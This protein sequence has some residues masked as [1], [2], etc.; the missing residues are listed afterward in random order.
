[1]Y[2]SVGTSGLVVRVITGL[3]VCGLN[4]A[5][6]HLQATLTKLLKSTQPSTLSKM[7]NKY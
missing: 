7:E 2:W 6:G 5:T 4:L 3:S 1:L